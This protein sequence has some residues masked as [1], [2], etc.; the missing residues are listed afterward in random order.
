MALPKPSRDQLAV[1]VVFAVA[2]ATVAVF[3]WGFGQQ[4]ALA[5]QMRVEEMRL[6]QAVAAERALNE[7]LKARLEYVK[8]DQC[9]EHWARAKMKMG[10]PGEVVVVLPK[11][12]SEEQAVDIQPT[13]SPNPGAQSFWN[14]WWELFF[15]SSR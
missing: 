4:L 10:K 15:G 6:E 9:V 3:V 12:S 5:R 14:E 1:G 7:D 2:L 8:S 11:A 13:P